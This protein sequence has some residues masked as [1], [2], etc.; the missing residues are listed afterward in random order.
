M[1][2]NTKACGLTEDIYEDV[3]N[4]F[5]KRKDLVRQHDKL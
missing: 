1:N 5:E 2:I 3:T 4:M